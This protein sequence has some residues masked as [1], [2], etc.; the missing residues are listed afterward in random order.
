MLKPDKHKTLNISTGFVLQAA[1]EANCKRPTAYSPILRLT[2]EQ[3]RNIIYCLL[4]KPYFNGLC[5]DDM[6]ISIKNR[7]IMSAVISGDDEQRS[8]YFH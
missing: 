1:I 3:S 8:A 4:Q 5:I 6:Q 2:A 7:V